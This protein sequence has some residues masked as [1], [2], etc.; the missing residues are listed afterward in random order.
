VTL[1]IVETSTGPVLVDDDESVATSSAPTQL[2]ELAEQLGVDADVFRARL[3]EEVQRRRR[4]RGVA[5]AQLDETLA[6]RE[7]G[8]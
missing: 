8:C 1:R 7:N 5:W 4:E 6:K 3:R 2:E